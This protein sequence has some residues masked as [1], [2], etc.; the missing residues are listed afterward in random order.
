MTRIIKNNKNNNKVSLIN[1]LELSTHLQ[2]DY[3]DY[4]VKLK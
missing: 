1:V 4:F 3:Y 2:I